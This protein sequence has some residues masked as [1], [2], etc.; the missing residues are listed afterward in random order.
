M[1]PGFFETDMTKNQMSDGLKDYWMAHCPLKRMG[2]LDELANVI[3]FL[4]SEE[5]SF[6]NGQ[7]LPVTGGLDW[8]G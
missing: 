7:V 6:V 2:A 5:A 3:L 4:A 8:A 1:A